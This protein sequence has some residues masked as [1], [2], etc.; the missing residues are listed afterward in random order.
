MQIVLLY[1]AGSSG[2]LH[3]PPEYLGLQVC[4]HILLTVLFLSITHNLYIVQPTFQKG[5]IQGIVEGSCDH[6]K[7]HL[8]TFQVWGRVL[9]P[10]STC[11]TVVK[12]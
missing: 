10:T 1:S 12:T 7:V 8:K 2:N 6:Y 4:R 9:L 11:C 3:L 5:I